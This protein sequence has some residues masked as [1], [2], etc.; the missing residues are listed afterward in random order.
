MNRKAHWEQVYS[1]KSPLE[2]SW[3]QA[4]PTL[5]L[6]LIAIT[7]LPL[8]APIIDVGGGAS[9]LVDYLSKLG[10]QY[11]S[12]LDISGKALASLPTDAETKDT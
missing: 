10:Y 1:I 2:V 11:L 4:K 6:Q 9:I 5:S 8:D 3:Y 7:G 12:V